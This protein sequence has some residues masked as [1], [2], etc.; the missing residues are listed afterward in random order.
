MA[1]FIEFINAPNV[2][3]TNFSAT[4]VQ[5]FFIISFSDVLNLYIENAFFGDTTDI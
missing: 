2:T 4:Y 3:I 5:D 1:K